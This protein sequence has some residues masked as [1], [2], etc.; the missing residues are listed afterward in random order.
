MAMLN[1][2]RGTFGE[3]TESMD[4]DVSVPG[5]RERKTEKDHGIDGSNSRHCQR[6]R[7]F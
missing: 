7:V 6:S 1:A 5:G 4:M 2:V 3:A